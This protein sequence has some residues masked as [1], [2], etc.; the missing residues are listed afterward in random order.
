MSEKDNK[1]ITKQVYY[2]IKIKLASPLNISSG[3]N[4]YTD[5]DVLKNKDGE[6]FIPGTS[7]AGAFRNSINQKKDEK[8]F[9]GYSNGREGAM[10]SIYISDLYFDKNNNI[11]NQVKVRDAVALNDEKIV[12]NKF[13]YQIVN[14]GLE[15]N[16][17]LH[18][19]VREGD[20]EENIKNAVY[21]F[22]LDMEKGYIRFGANK[23]RGLG[24]VNILA[25]KS[26][27]FTKDNAKD[28]L[29]FK[30]NIKDCANYDEMISID[31]I[32]KNLENVV[33]NSTSYSKIT[34]PL[35]LQGGISIRSYSAQKG[36]PD[37]E[38]ITVESETDGKLIPVIPGS[39]WN[40]A[41]R[42][43][44]KRVLNDLGCKKTDNYLSKWFGYVRVTGKEEKQLENVKE[45]KQLENVTEKKPSA[46]SMVV[47]AESRIEG[48]VAMNTTRNKINRFDNSTIKGALYT[49]RAYFGG[50]TELEIMINNKCEKIDALKAVLGIVIND[51][52]KGYVAIGGQVAIGRGVFS[53][54]DEGMANDWL[55]EDYRKALY[56]LLID[57]EV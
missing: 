6:I 47:I 34:V 17:F 18:Y 27:E 22:I 2:A 14:P 30:S 31:V 55:E 40:G 11:R 57:E 15:G 16:L 1:K 19:I 21:R 24:R 44:V 5:S 41:I 39:S 46:Q 13:D 53:P 56:E 52:A 29:V 48:A 9:M 50:T 4:V 43:D 37:F 35:N 42:A 12:D 23:N 38:H 20:D 10:S 51:I 8:G 26:R 49:E 36:A 7:I 25:V 28:L 33:V 3:E 45:E 54:V 32:E